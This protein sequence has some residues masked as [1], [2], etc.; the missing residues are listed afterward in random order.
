M[1]PSQYSLQDEHSFEEHGSSQSHAPLKRGRDDTVNALGSGPRKRPYALYILLRKL[2]L[3]TFPA[4]EPTPSF[5]MGD[6]L[7]VPYKHSVK[8]NCCLNRDLREASY[9][10]WGASQRIAWRKG[11]ALSN[12]MTTF[13]T[14]ILPPSS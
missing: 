4:A 12:A 3:L 2:R 9:L 1:E 10:S 13:L 8:C 11:V 6:I 5:I 14:D 7:G